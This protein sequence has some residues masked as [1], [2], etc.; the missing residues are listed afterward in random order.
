MQKRYID[1]L[2][3]LF[4]DSLKVKRHVH[5]NVP[6]TDLR[7]TNKGIDEWISKVREFTNKVMESINML[8]DGSSSW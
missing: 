2:R 1:I 7:N 8:T 5:Y 4:K 6:F 3:T